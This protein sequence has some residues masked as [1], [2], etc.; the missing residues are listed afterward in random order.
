M[1]DEKVL[2]FLRRGPADQD[3]KYGSVPAVESVMFDCTLILWN[4]E[5]IGII[6]PSGDNLNY[7]RWADQTYFPTWGNT[8]P[9]GWWT[10]LRQ[11][12]VERPPEVLT[13]AEYTAE[14]LSIKNLFEATESE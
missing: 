12:S 5:Y 4:T 10:V 13:F 9:V 11:G 2:E 3:W 8:P 6:V 7:L 1:P 14:V